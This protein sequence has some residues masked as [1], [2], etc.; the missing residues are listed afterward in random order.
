[1]IYSSYDVYHPTSKKRINDFIKY[2]KWKIPEHWDV[3]S[4]VGSEVGSGRGVLTC[5]VMA[6]LALVNMIVEADPHLHQS[7]KF[8]L[9]DAQLWAE[10]ISQS[11]VHYIPESLA[12]HIITDES[13]TRSKDVKKTLLFCISSAE[14]L[15]YLCEK[16]NL[17]STIRGKYLNYLCQ[18]ALRLAFHSQDKKLADNVLKMKNNFCIKDWCHFYGAQNRLVYYGFKMFASIISLFRKKETHWQ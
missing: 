2:R 15:L 16:Y 13:A 9:G 7:Q 4:F 17:S 18:S 8:L 10:I 6:R 12:T 3:E 14:L 1:M 5:T 11:R